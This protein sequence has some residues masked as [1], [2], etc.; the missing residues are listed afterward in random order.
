VPSLKRNMVASYVGQGF[1]SAVGIVMLPVFVHY[2][3]TEAF[4]LVGF[5]TMLQ[6]WSM[7]LDMGMTPTLSRE[8][9]RFSAGALPRE[10]VAKMIR[11]MEWIFLG[12]GLAS[13]GAVIGSAG[14]IGQHWLK[15]KNIGA[16]EL[17]LCVAL[18]GGML[19]LQWLGGV[20]RAG[21]VGLERMVA[22]NVAVVLAVIVRT[23]GSWLVLKYV[24]AAPR[25]YFLFHLSATVVEILVYRV[26]FYARFS[27]KGAGPWPAMRS[28][29]GSRAMAGG[30][31]FLATLWIVISQSDK[32]ML[33]WL[34]DLSAYGSFTVAASLAGGISTLAGPM[35][36]ALQPRLVALA[37]QGNRAGLED[38]YRTST[39]LMTIGLFAIAGTMAVFG[40]P[41]LLAWTGNPEIA[42]RGGRILALYALGNATA[43]V[44]GLAFT[45]QFAFGRLRWQMI[46][47]CAFG[48]FW[49]PGGYLAALRFGAVG[50]GTIWFACNVLYLLL[51]LPYI[52]SRILPGLWRRWLIVD[53]GLVVLFDGIVL[54]AARLVGIPFSNRMHVLATLV[55][56]TVL[57]AIL[58]MLVA[59]LARRQGIELVRRLRLAVP[60]QGS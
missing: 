15:A 35:A 10:Q 21:L 40:R 20:Y 46:G 25:A 32:L 51:W 39:Q 43:A 41:L 48:L 4:G 42:E 47:S 59:P 24:S 17:G 58:G 16:D 54:A 45:V 8:L 37:A 50:T 18:M 14:W 36:Q 52:H 30:M 22:L 3:G 27:M 7:L 38:L 26:L 11:T 1:A 57:L 60:R 28:L 53:V 2:L 19:G 5:F 31:A 9:A 12:L 33:S 55:L 13:A 34:L 6:S 49:V 44:L 56:G 23:V 29:Y